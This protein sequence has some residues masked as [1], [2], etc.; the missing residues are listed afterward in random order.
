MREVPDSTAQ[1][2]TAAF[3][4]MSALARNE[5]VRNLLERL[6]AERGDLT[7]KSLYAVLVTAA[8][9]LFTVRLG[10]PSERFGWGG[11]E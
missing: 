11:R 6:A 7:V 8:V 3:G 9:V 10:R 5:A 2:M 1:L 4:L